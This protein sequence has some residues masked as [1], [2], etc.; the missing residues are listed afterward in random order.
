MSSRVVATLGK[1]RDNLWGDTSA[2]MK[3]KKS[4]KIFGKLKAEF[5]AENQVNFLQTK[6]VFL[7]QICEMDK[8]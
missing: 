4:W 5:I 3:M 1:G 6:K 8:D 7:I 2:R